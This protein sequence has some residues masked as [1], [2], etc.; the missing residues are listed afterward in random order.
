MQSAELAATQP[1]ELL[2]VPEVLDGRF[3]TNRRDREQAQLA[4]TNDLDA[5]TRMACELRG[6]Q[7]YLRQLSQGS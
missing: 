4:A 1:V 2:V 7:N 3:V 5:V 6:H